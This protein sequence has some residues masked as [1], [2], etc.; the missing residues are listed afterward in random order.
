MRRHKLVLWQKTNIAQKLPS[1]LNDK[2]LSFQKFVIKQRKRHGNSLSLIGNMDETPM[3]FDLVGNRTVEHRG[4]KSVLVKTT[5]HEKQHFTVVLACMADGSKLPPMVIFKRKT[6]PKKEKFPP[7]VV[8]H[9]QPRGW[10]D[11]DGC[12]KWIERVWNGRPGGL[13]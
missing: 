10:M 3:F 6:F 7:G 9:V 1:D 5:G 4:N 11:E 8:V 2:V 12:K 13:L